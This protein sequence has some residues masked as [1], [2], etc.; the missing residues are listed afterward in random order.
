M[1][2]ALD[3]DDLA[4]LARALHRI[5]DDDDDNPN[6][7]HYCGYGDVRAVWAPNKNTFTAMLR[8]RKKRSWAWS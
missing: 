2:V 8:P 6:T 5:P 4:I 3:Y 7:E 1:R